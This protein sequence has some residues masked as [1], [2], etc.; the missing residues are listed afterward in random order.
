MK[1]LAA[2][3]EG[4]ARGDNGN[5]RRWRSCWWGARL[6]GAVGL[7]RRITKSR[8]AAEV[9]QARRKNGRRWRSRWRGARFAGAVGLA[10]RWIRGLLNKRMQEWSL[11]LLDRYKGP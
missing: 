1:H 8:L 11:R 3:A 9:A 10:K 2:A 5:G 4:Q 7:A 6:A